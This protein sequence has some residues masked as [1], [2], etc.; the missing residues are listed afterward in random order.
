MPMR[1][2]VAG[3]VCDGL[4]ETLAIFGEER[5]GRKEG[6]SRERG[7]R[8]GYVKQYISSLEDDVRVQRD[9][10]SKLRCYVGMRRHP[11]EDGRR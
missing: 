1:C 4:Y 11:Q 3:L 6:A 2:C 7:A 10:S 9:T 8:N 5:S